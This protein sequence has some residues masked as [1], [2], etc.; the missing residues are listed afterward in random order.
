MRG[1]RGLGIGG[2]GAPTPGQ[3]AVRA[4][5]DPRNS[6]RMY[7]PGRIA[8]R[9]RP[10]GRHDPCFVE[11]TMRNAL[12]IL[13]LVLPAPLAAQTPASSDAGTRTAQADTPSLRP[14][15]R[16]QANI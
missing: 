1:D 8:Q 14:R 10:S 7:G 9:S 4:R 12:V 5:S 11:A 2:W 13:A 6:V 15:T 16:T 3:R